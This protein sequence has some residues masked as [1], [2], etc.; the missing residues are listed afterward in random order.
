[1][2]IILCF[3]E[4]SYL[5]T[6]YHH[7]VCRKGLTPTNWCENYNWRSVYLIN[8]IC[9]AV[10]YYESILFQNTEQTDG[11]VTIID[12]QFDIMHSKVTAYC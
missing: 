10:L 7:Y 2:Y 1:M 6:D 8:F 4:P 11:F 9:K 3:T 5:I 12:L